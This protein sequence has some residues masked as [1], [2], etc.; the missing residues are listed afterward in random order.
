MS[1]ATDAVVAKDS[2][3]QPLW[4]WNKPWH[5]IIGYAGPPVLAPPAIEGVVLDT[6]GRLWIWVQTPAGQDP[7]TGW[8]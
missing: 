1:L 3:G 6:N 2:A 5:N 8:K 4:P 7:L